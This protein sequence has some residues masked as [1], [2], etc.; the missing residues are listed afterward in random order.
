[1]T[2]SRGA[3]RDLHELHE[4]SF[5]DRQRKLDGY[6]S[7]E[8]SSKSCLTALGWNS[9]FEFWSFTLNAQHGKCRTFHLDFFTST[10]PVSYR[11]LADEAF[12]NT[13]LCGHISG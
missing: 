2:N 5:G 7:A 9:W 12:M 10:A 6:T 3:F 11:P 4:I 8:N 13:D 1:M